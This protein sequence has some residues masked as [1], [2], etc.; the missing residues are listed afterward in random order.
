MVTLYVFFLRDDADVPST[1]LPVLL[2]FEILAF[3]V[4]L[5]AVTLQ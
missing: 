4:P 1:I 2:D 5:V 3:G